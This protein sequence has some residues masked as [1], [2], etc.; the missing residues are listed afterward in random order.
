MT[1]E[2]FNFLIFI[3]FWSEIL[4]SKNHFLIKK[5]YDQWLKI[6]SNFKGELISKWLFEANVK[7]LLYY[8]G[9][10]S[11]IFFVRFLGE[12]KT[13]NIHVE[14]NLPYKQMLTIAL[15]ALHL[16]NLN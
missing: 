9:T 2:T 7:I 14:I 8:Y 10:W 3:W 6:E 1:D 5:N 15:F 4:G 11:R 13:S 16:F 12:L